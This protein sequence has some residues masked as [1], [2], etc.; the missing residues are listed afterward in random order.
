MNERTAPI[1]EFSRRRYDLHDRTL[2]MGIINVTPDSFSDGGRFNSTDAALV[3]A[4]EMVAEGADILDVGGES[5]RPGGGAVSLQEELDR[6]VPVVEKLVAEFALPVSVDTTKLEV[7]RAALGAGAEIVNDISGLRFEPELADSVAEYSAGLILMHSRGELNSLHSQ[8]PLENIFDEVINSL[9]GAVAKAERRGVARKSI[10]LDPGVGFSKT[11]EQNLALVANFGK[12]IEALP[13]F[14]W[15]I[16]TS[17][18]SFIGKILGNAPVTDRLSGSLATITTAVLG[19]AH[20]VR[21]HDVKE[22][23]ATVRM[24]EAL[25]NSSETEPAL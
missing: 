23:V 14:G 13:E 20:L 1:W 12:L 15:M 24:A 9:R 4:A 25:K 10:V 21:V 2:V 11:F 7:A 8:P 19:G 6:V 18:K 17:R 3:R 22:T 16:G 5:T